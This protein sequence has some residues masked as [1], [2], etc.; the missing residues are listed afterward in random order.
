VEGGQKL[1]INQHSKGGQ[2]NASM[3]EIDEMLTVL[4]AP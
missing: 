3:D 1:T 2:G 4:L